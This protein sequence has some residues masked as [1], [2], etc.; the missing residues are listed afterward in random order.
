M[1]SRNISS[2]DVISQLRFP[3]IVLVTYAHSYGALS[4]DYSLVATGFDGYALLRLLV[5]QSLVKVVVPLFFIFSGY[6]FFRQTG[7]WSWRVY[8][9]KLRRRVVTLL[10]PYVVWNLLMAAKLRTFSWQVF[11]TFWSQAGH[12]TDWL[13]YDNW[14]T[15]PADMPLWFLRD[16]MVVTLLTPVLY[17][18]LRHVGTL[19]VGLLTLL[20][21][22]GVCAFTL[23]GLSAYAVYFFSLGAWLSIGRHDLVAAARR[24]EVAAYVLSLLLLVAMLL[25]W[26][27]PMFSSLMLAFRLTGAAAVLC[28]TSR[29]LSATTSRLPQWIV[30]SSYFLYLAHYVIFLSFVDD[31]LFLVFGTTSTLS[32]C[33]HYLLAPL[34]KAA[35][36]VAVYQ[37][38]Y[39]AFKAKKWPN[40]LR[41]HRK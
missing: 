6:L 32:L 21:L 27:L 36:L 14:M 12:Q 17:L 18:V 2:S 33:L 10:V 28:L 25:S 5:S 38:W 1:K 29:L 7:Q 35:L 11:W 40:V 3:L 8:G 26:H 31:G 22:S 16:L 13:G 9:E 19:F 34:V 37:A 20:Y 30:R 24:V 23:P 41:F 4:P 15:A 39:Y